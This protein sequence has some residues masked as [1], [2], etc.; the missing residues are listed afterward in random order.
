MATGIGPLECPFCNNVFLTSA[1]PRTRKLRKCTR[2]KRQ[3]FYYKGTYFIS[4]RDIDRYN[5]GF[6]FSKLL[7]RKSR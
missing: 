1:S 6:I 3:F 7:R 2:C 5:R 4:I